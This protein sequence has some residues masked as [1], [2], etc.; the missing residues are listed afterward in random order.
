MNKYEK[1][2]AQVI[3][4]VMSVIGLVAIF[5]ALTTSLDIPDVLISHSTNECVSVINYTDEDTYSCENMPTKYNK[6]WVK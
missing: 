3:G 1:Y 2:P 4:I 6:V 5:F